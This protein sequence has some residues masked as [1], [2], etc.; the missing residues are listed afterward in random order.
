MM[1]AASLSRSFFCFFNFSEGF[2]RYKGPRHHDKKRK[3]KKGVGDCGQTRHFFVKRS[4]NLKPSSLF[5]FPL[6]KKK[7]KTYHAVSGKQVTP[8]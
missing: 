5:T 3:K 1:M 2:F 4:P 7:K 8:V 6:P